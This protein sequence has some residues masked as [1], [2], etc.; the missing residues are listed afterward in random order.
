MPVTVLGFLYTSVFDRVL[1]DQKG[2]VLICFLYCFLY[3]KVETEGNV[4]A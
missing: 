2:V 4:T 1:R 3:L